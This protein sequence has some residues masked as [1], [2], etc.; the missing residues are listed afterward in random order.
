MF[1]WPK[2][3]F[4]CALSELLVPI[5]L[6]TIVKLDCLKGAHYPQSLS[7]IDNN[8]HISP[9]MTFYL[10][11]WRGMFFRILEREKFYNWR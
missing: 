1:L 3:F 9:Y 6:R 11:A 5:R 10:Y 8:V 2:S 4:T 7:L